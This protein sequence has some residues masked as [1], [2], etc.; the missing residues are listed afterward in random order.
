MDGKK[1]KPCN[2]VGNRHHESDMWGDIKLFRDN[3]KRQRVASEELGKYSQP[4]NC[5]NLYYA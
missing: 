4:K 1:G 2:N 3:N 5:D